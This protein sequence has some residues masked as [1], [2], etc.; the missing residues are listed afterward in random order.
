MKAIFLAALALG[1]CSSPDIERLEQKVERLTER[2]AKNTSTLTEIE[3]LVRKISGQSLDDAEAAPDKPE[4]VGVVANMHIYQ[5]MLETYSVDWGGVYPDTVEQLLKEATAW[6][7]YKAFANPY[8][9]E[10]GMKKAVK[11][12]TAKEGC[13]SG[14]VYYHLVNQQNY[15]VTGCTIERTPTL[16]EENKLL[17]LSN[18]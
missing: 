10:T 8:S 17:I 18:S 4:E 3:N 1:M 5:I 16:N 14:M 15:E 2:Q 9:G 11:E 6:N 13:E 12:G 7:Y